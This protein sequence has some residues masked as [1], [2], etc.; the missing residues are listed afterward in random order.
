M[1]YGNAQIIVYCRLKFSVYRLRHDAASL[2]SNAD[3]ANQNSHDGGQDEHGA[4]SHAR[5][6]MDDEPRAASG[7][8]PSERLASYI[9]SA[10]AR[11]SCW[12]YN[13]TLV[14]RLPGINPSLNN[15]IT[16]QSLMH[17]AEISTAMPP[18]STVK[19]PNRSAL[20]PRRPTSS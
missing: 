3:S 6:C 5:Q 2:R 4:R 16:M 1:V 18:P 9:A 19:C 12:C 7:R 15:N 14:F 10:F 13:R 8:A 11:A 20:D 17:A